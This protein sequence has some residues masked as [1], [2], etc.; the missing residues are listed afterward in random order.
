MIYVLVKTG[1]LLQINDK[2]ILKIANNKAQKR[3]YN[4][5]FKRP[6]VQ[7]GV[8]PIYKCALKP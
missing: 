5:N 3:D 2:K 4:R 1:I 6:S 8:C 7:R